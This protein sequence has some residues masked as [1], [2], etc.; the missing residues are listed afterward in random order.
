MPGEA[1][2]CYCWPQGELGEELAAEL[3]SYGIDPAATGMTGEALHA[4]RA[5]MGRRRA[6]A[7]AALP[8]RTRA[9]FAFLRSALAGHI[10]QAR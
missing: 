6:A 1:G 3:A 10:S 4:A 7:A 9:R 8:P 2:K 5:E